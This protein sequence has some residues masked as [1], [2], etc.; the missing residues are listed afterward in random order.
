MPLPDRFKTTEDLSPGEHV[1]RLQAENRGEAAPR[2]ETSAYRSY[3]QE[4]LRAGQL[5]EEADEAEEGAKALVDM[6]PDDHFRAIQRER[7]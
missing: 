2:F 3:R 5:N 6:T 4:V 1:A 7:A